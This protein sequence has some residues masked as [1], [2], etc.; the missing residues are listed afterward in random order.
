MSS[1][2]YN[3]NNKNITYSEK[4]D[5]IYIY[6]NYVNINFTNGS[7]TVNIGDYFLNDVVVGNNLALTIGSASSATVNGD[8]EWVDDSAT[9]NVLTLNGSWS[10]VNATAGG[11]T[12]NI[13]NNS[14]NNVINGNNLSLTIGSTSSATVNGTG[15]SI[16]FTGS[17]STIT[18]SNS[19]IYM[20][21]NQSVTINGYNNTVYISE[22]DEIFTKNTNY[23]KDDSYRV[24]IKNNGQYGIFDNFTEEKGSSS[25]TVSPSDDSRI[26]SYNVKG[27]NL[28]VNTYKEWTEIQ[29]TTSNTLST[30]TVE[31]MSLNEN[32]QS[33]TSKSDGMT[34]LSEIDTSSI[35]NENNKSKFLDHLNEYNKL[36]KNDF[37]KNH[38][39]S[40]DENYFGK[41]HMYVDDE[42]ILKGNGLGFDE[43]NIHNHSHFLV[44]LNEKYPL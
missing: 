12:F 41:N 43:I 24:I 42:H 37:I 40:T 15:D 38:S 18:A 17:N 44:S 31:T 13:G 11:D 7:D 22:K 35:Q 14:L 25:Y 6:G 32:N 36:S 34:F 29:N 16:Y 5:F 23:S 2:T 39:L 20:E 10:T 8:G 28:I 33:L 4:G 30:S 21:P 9:G 27:N 26:Q 1:V 3:G 19:T